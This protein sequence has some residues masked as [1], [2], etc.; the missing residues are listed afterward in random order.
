MNLIGPLSA[1]LQSL[2]LLYATAPE[3]TVQSLIV[4]RQKCA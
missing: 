4:L 2:L 3:V 1:V